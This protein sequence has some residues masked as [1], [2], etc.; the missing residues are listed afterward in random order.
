M[1][2]GD[3][4]EPVVS[5]PVG[6]VAAVVAAVVATTAVVAPVTETGNQS[7]Q[8][9]EEQEILDWRLLLIRGSVTSTAR[10][11]VV[12]LWICHEKAVHRPHVAARGT[13]D[14]GVRRIAV[15]GNFVVLVAAKVRAVTRRRIPASRNHRRHEH[16]APRA[17]TR[18]IGVGPRLRVQEA[19]RRPHVAAGGP[20]NV[21]L[22][23][24]TLP[25]ISLQV[26]PAPI[27]AVFSLRVPARGPFVDQRIDKVVG[28]G[29]ADCCFRVRQL[30]AMCQGVGGTKQCASDT[31]LREGLDPGR[32]TSFSF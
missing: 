24:V 17:H 28:E 19:V 16:F 18:L 2:V 8:D 11:V 32:H 15:P 12:H 20:R 31:N 25:V 1:P 29:V 4:V 6:A 5:I 3:L 13:V 10:V 27:R 30:D 7:F 21:R 9:P 26:G 23:R 14:G 22:A